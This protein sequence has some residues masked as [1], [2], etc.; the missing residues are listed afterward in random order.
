MDGPCA[1]EADIVAV[2]GAG[3]VGAVGVLAAPLKT[4]ADGL[5]CA[6]HGGGGRAASA[7]SCG[8]GAGGALAATV[9]AAAAAGTLSADVDGRCVRLLSAGGRY[10]AMTTFFSAP[11]LRTAVADVDAPSRLPT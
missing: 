10:M 7:S 5:S 9:A 8:V 1:P 4:A 2:P 6:A 11:R 3:R